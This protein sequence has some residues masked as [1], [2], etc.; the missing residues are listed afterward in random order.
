MLFVSKRYCSTLP[1]EH[2]VNRF[3]EN[4]EEPP[5]VGLT[6]CPYTGFKNCIRKSLQEAA[7]DALLRLGGLCPP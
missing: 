2:L 1:L 7:S 6:H 5:A 4:I 3:V